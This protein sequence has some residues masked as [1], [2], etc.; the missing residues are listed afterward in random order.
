MFWALVC[1][2]CGRNSFGIFNTEEEATLNVCL[3]DSVERQLAV[4]VRKVVL[5]WPLF[6]VVDYKEV[7]SR[8]NQHINSEITFGTR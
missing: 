2:H 1:L 8:L 4:A 6:N 5:V 3:I 7:A